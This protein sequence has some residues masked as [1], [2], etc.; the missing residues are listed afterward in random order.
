M[1]RQQLEE[2]FIPRVIPD[3]KTQSQKIFTREFIF[4]LASHLKPAPRQ[5]VVM[6]DPA[7]IALRNLDHLLPQEA[8]GSCPPPEVDFLWLRSNSSQDTEQASPGI[9]AVRGEHLP[10][11]LKLWK[12]TYV[13]SRRDDPTS[14][15]GAIWTKT[16]QKLS[17]RKRAFEGTEVIA[18]SFQSV[19]WQLLSS[20]AFVTV[21]DWPIEEQWKLIQALYFGTYFGDESGMILNM[22]DT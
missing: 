1:A 11:V 9:W 17:I 16:V 5:W 20:A 21:P 15:E 4:E 2:T 19:D 7:S 3:D 18:P 8:H 14:S 10:K 12:E 6:M 22:L 13:R